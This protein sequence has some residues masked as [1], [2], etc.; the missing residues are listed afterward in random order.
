MSTNQSHCEDLTSFYLV[1]RVCNQGNI[2]V[3]ARNIGETLVYDS[4]YKL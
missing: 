2:D 4:S 1:M 3:L